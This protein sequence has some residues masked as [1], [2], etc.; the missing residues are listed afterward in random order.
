MESTIKHKKGQ[1][2][3][4][5]ET[6]TTMGTLINSATAATPN[7]D[8]FV[9]T[10]E[11][12]GLLKKI[13]WTGVKSFLKSYFDG[14][15]ASLV[16]PS[17]TGTPTAPTAT[18]G[19]NTTQIATTAF[20]QSAVGSNVTQTIT[21]GVTT[22]SPSEDAVFDALALKASLSG[23]TF[24]GDISSTNFIT[25][26][27]FITGST[28]EG[29]KAPNNGPISFIC[30]NPSTPGW[31]ANTNITA[32]FYKTTVYT[33]STLPTTGVSSGT[34]ATVSDA[35]APAYLTTVVGGGGRWY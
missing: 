22:T 25:G 4:N 23:G 13:T 29:L 20:V 27:S 18:A 34:Y 15:Y 10:A 8:D 17:F 2:E 19:T 26:G 7:N 35:L 32:T 24:T 12:D 31:T 28:Y 30:N 1:L 3:N 5:P 6:T 33:V 11:S 9:A 16:S 14:I 21:N